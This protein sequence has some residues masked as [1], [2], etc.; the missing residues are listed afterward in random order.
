VCRIGGVEGSRPL[1]LACD[2][3]DEKGMYQAKVVHPLSDLDPTIAPDLEATLWQLFVAI[4]T[5]WQLPDDPLPYR[6]R[7][8]AFLANRIDLNPLYGAYYTTAKQVIN[9]LVAAHGATV[10]FE[11]I[12]TSKS[13]QLPPP[14]PV[15]ELDITQQY[16]ANEFISFRLALG[17]FKAFG[18]INYPGYMGGANIPG[19]PV[20]YRPMGARSC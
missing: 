16:V 4:G 8:R 17:S 2:N 10:A 15:T 6:L 7:F 1:L 3:K 19:E 5:F 14:S 9:D 20:P 13:H 18:A 12:F 11:T